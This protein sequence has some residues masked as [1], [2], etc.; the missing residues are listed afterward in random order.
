MYSNSLG[1]SMFLQA[2]RKKGERSK[3]SMH[4]HM[5]IKLINGNRRYCHVLVTRQLGLD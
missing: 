3:Y 2:P 1:N 5:I 4:V